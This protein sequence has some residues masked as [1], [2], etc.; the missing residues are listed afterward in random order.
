MAILVQVVICNPVEL[1]ARKQ[2]IFAPDTK[3]WDTI[4]KKQTKPIIFFYIIKIKL[5]N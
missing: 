5:S 3:V 4:T 1:E 2:S